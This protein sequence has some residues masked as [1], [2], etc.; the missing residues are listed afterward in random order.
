MKATTQVAV[1]ELNGL[2]MSSL[3]SLGYT[4]DEAS[5][6]T[7][8][9]MYAQL[10]GNNQGIIKITTGGM[11]RAKGAGPI[12]VERD[13]RLAAIINGHGD[14]GMLVLNKARDMAAAKCLKHGFGIVGTNNTYTSTGC[15]AYYAEKLAE[16]GMIG[17]VLAQSPEFV[18]PVGAKQAIFGTNPICVSVPAADGP[19]TM[20]MATAA[21]AWFGVLEAK[22]A[23][24]QL[25]SGVAM[26][27]DGHDTTDPNAVLSGGSLKVFDGS[28]KGSALAL[29]VELL[30][31]PLVGAA[32]ADKMDEKSWGNLLIAIDPSLLQDPDVFACRAQEVLDRVKSAARQPGVDEILL[33]GERSAAKAAAVLAS[34]HVEVETNLLEGLRELA[35]TA[36]RRGSSI[37]KYSWGVSTRLVHPSPADDGVPDPATSMSAPIY[38][39][40]T[41][42]QPAATEGG[43]YDYTRSGNPTRAILERN[44]AELEE[45]DGALAFVTGMAAINAAVRLVKSGEHILAGDDIYGGTSR[46]LGSVLPDL[47]IEVSN[48]DH[49]DLH[50]YK[51]AF[52]PRKT[53]L[54][55]LESPT[56]PRM[57]VCDLKALTDIAHANGALVMVD[58]SI[59]TPIFQKPLELGADISMV[60]ATKF[61]GGHSDVTGG[62]LAFKDKALAD[63]VYF[64]QNAEGTGLPPFECWLALRG[65]KTMKLRMDAAVSNAEAMAQFLS[66]HPLIQQVNYANLPGTPDAALNARQATS[67]G[68]LLSFTTG[69][70]AVSKYIV[71]QTQLFSIT[72]SFG[73]VSSLISMPCY[74]SH[75][76]IPA[77]VRAVRGLPDDLVR[78]S[79]GIE[80][81]DDLLADLSAAL[82]GAA[83]QV[84]GYGQADAGDHSKAN[85]AAAATTADASR[86]AD[87]LRRVEELEAALVSQNGV[88]NPTVSL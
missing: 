84:A 47:G 58:N 4:R 69:D 24:A 10:R 2:C 77:E 8:V 29:F 71:E 13:T 33:P 44:M 42:K 30:A 43:P 87:L 61:V 19:V 17:V 6:L 85:G 14:A 3:Q 5:V 67:G 35:T 32:V 75:A 79:A 57:R 74:M 31:G 59:M 63:R 27:S 23:G 68:A 72:V 55:I 54:V 7:E 65:M 20:D 37:S 78:I 88:S 48:V 41:F 70:V 73:S 9:M 15:L 1:E 52:I 49:T 53:K 56:N 50:A 46:L 66:S 12:A 80:D 62:I 51:R 25:P 36:A 11:N 86:E 64:F 83:A 76:S 60:S 21:Y 18:A 39:T 22:T 81:I 34:G 82:D 26:D 45:G 38:Q 28:Y 16:Q 40:A